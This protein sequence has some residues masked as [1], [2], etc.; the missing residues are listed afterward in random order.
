MP[1]LRRM[2][3]QEVLAELRLFGF[4]LVSQRGSHIKLR[5][6]GPD[7]RKTDGKHPEYDKTDAE[8]V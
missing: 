6:L 4:E 3:G 7:G 1:S 5:R 8:R 2:S